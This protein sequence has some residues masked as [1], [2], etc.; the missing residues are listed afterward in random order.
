METIPETFDLIVKGGDCMTPSGRACGDVGVKDGTC[1]RRSVGAWCGGA[2]WENQRY[3][4][5]RL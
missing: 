4:G 1:P 2:Q 3:E 5:P